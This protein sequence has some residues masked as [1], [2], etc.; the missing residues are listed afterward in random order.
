MHSL[1]L[2]VPPL[3]L[4]VVAAA[5]MALLA[6]L[7]PRPALVF[8]APYALGGALVGLGAVIAIAGVLAFRRAHTTF[9]PMK[10]GSSS[11]VV[12]TGVYRLT[13]N[14]MYLGFLLALA[15]WG[16][17]LGNLLGLLPLAAFVAWMNRF[18]IA[19]EER[20]LRE[21]FGADFED[22]MHRVRRW[23]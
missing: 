7:F 11:S 16:A 10:P 8:P 15:G 9:N 6:W 13:R 20:A 23:V 17:M 14:P 19:P 5:L 21:K 2:R 3:A 22:Y 1:E 18:Q 4:V 12:S